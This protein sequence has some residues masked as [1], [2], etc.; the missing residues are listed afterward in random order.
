MS[1]IVIKIIVDSSQAVPRARAATKAIDEVAAST[2]RQAQAA[3]NAQIE[4][5]KQAK[6][7]EK[8]EKQSKKQSNAFTEITRA[9]RL[10]QGPLDGVS[11]RFQTLNT[12]FQEGSLRAVGFTLGVA[13]LTAGLV[14][15]FVVADKYTQLSARLE[16]V[17]KSTAQFNQAQN[18]L[19]RIAQN[20]RSSLGTTT[21]AFITFQQ[22]LARVG[23]TQG[24]VLQFTETLQ[25]TFRLSGTSAQN[26]SAAI[27]QLSQAFA[28]GKLDGDEFKSVLENN[29]LAGQILADQFTNGNVGA[30]FELSKAGKL[31][32]G[33]V[34]NAFIA[35]TDT[36]DGSFKRLPLNASQGLTLLENSFFQ[37]VGSIE[38]TFGFSQKLGEALKFVAD[39][40]ATL[41]D[42]VGIVAGAF[43]LRYAASIGAAILSSKTFI[44]TLAVLQSV[45]AGTFSVATITA[46]IA[47]LNPL[48][49]IIAVLT[50]A[51]L[52]YDAAVESTA[53][54][55]ARY[56]EES[57]KG[58]SLGDDLQSLNRQLL[59]ATGDYRKQL[60]EKIRLTKLDSEAKLENARAS[61]VQLEADLALLQ[62][63]SKDLDNSLL[64][65]LFRGESNDT[66][67]IQT[68]KSLGDLYKEI[69]TLQDGLNGKPLVVPEYSSGVKDVT[70][71][72]KK[73]K[74][75]A[76]E[77][78]EEQKLQIKYFEDQ[79]KAAQALSDSIRDGISD[80]IYNGFNGSGN[81]LKDFF[82]RLRQSF[83]RSIADGIAASFQTG[84]INNLTNSIF[85]VAG[86]LPKSLGGTGT[87]ASGGIGGGSGALSG[88][89]SVASGIFNGFNTPFLDA[90]GAERLASV[91]GL[92]NSASTI[93][94]L[95]SFTPLA[96]IAGFGGNFL[97][98]SIF[99]NNRGIG[100][101]LGG[102]AGGAVGTFAGGAA[103][104]PVLGAAA[105]PIGALAGA[106]LGNAIGGLFGGG[107]KPS[108]KLQGGNID[109][110]TGKI[111]DREALSQ[112]GKKF[113]QEN[114]DAVTAIGQYATG[115][116]SIFDLKNVGTIN[117]KVGARSKFEYGLGA[118]GT[119]EN[120]TFETADALLKDLTMTFAEL[121]N[122]SKDVKTA[123]ENIDFTKTEE[124]ISDLNFALKYDELGKAPKKVSEMEQ[125]L[126]S[127][128]D[129][130]D[131]DIKTAER[132][133][134]SIDKVNAAREKDIATLREQANQSVFLE[135]FDIINPK[136]NAT[137]AEAN[138][139]TTQLENIKAI[140]G[141]IQSVEL[142]HKLKMLQIEQQYGSELNTRQEEVKNLV[143]Q[144][145]QL[146]KSL[147]DAIFNLRV[148]NLS[149]VS[150]VDKLSEARARFNN[151]AALASQDTPEGRAAATEL[152]SLGNQFLELSR[153][154]NAS[155]QAF[156]DD[157]NAVEQGLKNAKS[158]AESQLSIQTS[159][160]STLNAQLLA[161]QTGFTALAEQIKAVFAP[162][163]SASTSGI[164]ENYGGGAFS[165][166]N[167]NEI[168]IRNLSAIQGAG[169]YGTLESLLTQFT[170]GVVSG[171][172]RRSAFFETNPLYGQQF[173][174]AAK[175][176]GIPGFARGGLIGSGRLAMVGEQ[177]PELVRFDRPAF[178]QPN[179]VLND[180]SSDAAMRQYMKQS[181]IETLELKGQLIE[182]TD[183]VVDLSRNIRRSN[184][185]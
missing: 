89:G 103:L 70:K 80:A 30:L 121:A 106:F 86:G 81:F 141:D 145:G 33:E 82:N 66:A 113:S 11:S 21:D 10:V 176:A 46:F 185:A 101:S 146:A 35:A 9:I 169:L 179:S 39:N 159:M 127:L 48:T 38:T 109:L 124:A 166:S 105:G 34:A 126:K 37:L 15:Y 177:G 1:D 161:T 68:L 43:A 84:I 16:L 62:K 8:L 172:G 13:G 168:A 41:A 157:F 94:G 56:N 59:T 36:I 23:L 175:A 96:G 83:F 6:A 7:L 100:A 183:V 135:I 2:K 99:G 155:S 45:M 95:S 71:E 104:T 130:Y 119:V 122:K 108:N 53:E 14:K 120:K 97:A 115:I 107:G 54:K 92:G 55:L 116:A 42:I 32:A 156:T 51:Y 147:D 50:A 137:I 149:P 110:L 31:S 79:Q 150:S 67:K 72:L 148:G 5:N 61:A 3:A 143:E 152:A 139:Y 20:T 19:F 138:R 49:K 181:A 111:S 163:P 18:E 136:I 87:S 131:A 112:S 160:L 154:Y 58:V 77:F 162:K 184:E 123:I 125:A 132:L 153:A 158:V 134:L 29:K 4:I 165:A 76:K 64:G 90:V 40:M 140:N 133:K 22:S 47:G 144:Y 27:L 24:Q 44:A 98:D 12:I 88:I 128:N 75:T 57:Q 63:T 65:N 91:F 17:T 28:K 60:V 85:G 73:Q 151:L 164:G 170:P 174:A 117:A 102:A 180:N 167:P 118:A 171:G 74:D 26:Q 78:T 114:A 142:L 173:Q 129:A 93:G 69:N 178:I 182:L 25:K 52:A